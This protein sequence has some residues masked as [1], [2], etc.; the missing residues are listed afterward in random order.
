MQGEAWAR[1]GRGWPLNAFRCCWRMGGQAVGQRLRDKLH[2]WDELGLGSCIPNA[3]AMYLVEYPF[4]CPD[5]LGGGE[6]QHFRT[7]QECLDQELMVRYVQ[8]S[9]LMP[10]MQFSDAPW[11]VLP[12]EHNALCLAAAKLHVTYGEL[13]KQLAHHAA[14]SGEPL[15]RHLSRI[16]SW[17]AKNSWW[18]RS[19]SKANASEQ[20][21]FLPAPESQMMGQFLLGQ[22]TLES[23]CR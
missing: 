9:A 7:D 8:A 15:R 6:Y 1:F 3:L 23:S 11:R 17:L 19:R 2:S 12:P 5:V 21:L 20:C 16:N 22:G 14:T 10:M 13:I 4:V 18:P